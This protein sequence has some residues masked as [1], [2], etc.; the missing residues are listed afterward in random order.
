MSEFAAQET[1]T[2]EINESVLEFDIDNIPDSLI[3]NLP[4]IE[5]TFSPEKFG[6]GEYLNIEY[7]EARFNKFFPGLL[8]QFPCLYYMVEE[9]HSEAIKRTPLDEILMNKQELNQ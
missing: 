1:T 3:F 6:I 7:Y 4:S 8:S 2:E 9:L 5:Y